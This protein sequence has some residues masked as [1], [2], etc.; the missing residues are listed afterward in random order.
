M[1]AM[2]KFNQTPRAEIQPS[3]EKYTSKKQATDS[4][5]KI[6]EILERRELDRSLAEFGDM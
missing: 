4:R 1:N 3:T 5:R 6:D 2:S